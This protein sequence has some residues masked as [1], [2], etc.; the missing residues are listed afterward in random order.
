MRFLPILLL[1]ACGGTGE[2]LDADGCAS[3]QDG[4]FT[5][6]TAGAA[7]DATAPAITTEGA[8]TVTLPATGVGYVSF[9]SL[10]DTEYI[11]FAD[12]TLTIA[13]FT[14]TGT[15][16]M[17]SARA[18]SVSACSIVHRRDVIELQVGMFYFALGPDAGGPI[19]IVLRPYNPD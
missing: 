6:I 17:A 7:K 3:L 2:S 10:D 4:P 12:R 19:R 14:P 1:S 11:A 9:E 5:T 18:T 8:F 16:I 13:A 15:E